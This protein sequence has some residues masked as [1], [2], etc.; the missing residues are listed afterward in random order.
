MERINIM[1]SSTVK[2]LVGERQCIQSIFNKLE[3]VNLLGTE[4]YSN[5]SIS[6]SSAYSTVKMAKE[7]DLYI[8]ILGNDFGFELKDGRSATEV[9]FD[10]AYHDDPTKIL[11]FLK[12]EETSVDT[13]QEKFI[14]RVC[15]YY[16]GYWRTS[17]KYTHELQEMVK[18]SFMNWLKDRASFGYSFTYLDHFIRLAIQKKPEPE[19]S[20]YYSVKKDYIELEYKSFNKVRCIQ[21]EKEQIYKDF[22]GCLY[23]LEQ[24]VESALL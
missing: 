1:V 24:Q 12:E 16:S 9:E 2:N 5:A 22:W 3:Y 17:F 23:S 19:T 4:P 18:N 13:R 20:V 15:N 8:L 21:F 10:A 11:V 6:G 7:C 14:K